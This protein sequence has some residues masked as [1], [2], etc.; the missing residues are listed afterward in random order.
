MVKR[1]AAQIKSKLFEPLDLISVIGFLR[2]FKLTCNINET[3]EGAAIRYFIFF[4]DDV[5]LCIL[6]NVVSEL[7]RLK[8]G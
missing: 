5:C 7:E 8:K 6:C 1:M 2:T 4:H 3:L